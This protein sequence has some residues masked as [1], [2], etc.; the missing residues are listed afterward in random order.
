[1]SNLIFDYFVFVSAGSDQNSTPITSQDWKSR[2]AVLER[3][4]DQNPKT[5]A[6][7]EKSESGNLEKFGLT[8]EQVG[9]FV[10]AIIACAD[11]DIR[12]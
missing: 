5:E 7:T 8:S 11:K 1:M 4:V 10:S 6:E 3:L 9:H 12:R 2:L